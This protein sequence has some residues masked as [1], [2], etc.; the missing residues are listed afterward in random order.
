MGRRIGEFGMLVAD[1]N[2]RGKGVGSALIKAAEQWAQRI[3]CT[4]MQL[5]LLT[6]RH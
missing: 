1:V 5:E 6:P 2:H 4:T 3:D